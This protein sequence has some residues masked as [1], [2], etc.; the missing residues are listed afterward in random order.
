VTRVLFMGRHAAAASALQWALGENFDIAG[1]LVGHDDPEDPLHA[2]ADKAGCRIMTMNEVCGEIRSGTISFDLGISFVFPHIIG[3]PLLSHPP[4]G[5]INLHPAPLP[6]FRGC[7]GYNIAILEGLDEWAVTAH[8]IDAGIDTGPVIEVVRFPIDPERETVRSLVETSHARMLDLCR[9]V[10]QR[11]GASGRLEADRVEGGRYISRQEMELLKKVA[12]GDDV[13][14]KIRAFW[15]PPHPG[16]WAEVDG[17]RR[18]L[19]SEFVRSLHSRDDEQ[20]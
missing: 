9:S 4:L 19:T 13:D 7:G 10:M 6:D 3:E 2:A 11:V 16:A 1:V 20:Q 17:K 18:E 14:R 5:T 15:Y 8:Y 12:E